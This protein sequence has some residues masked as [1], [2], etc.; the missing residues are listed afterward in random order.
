MVA[1]PTVEIPGY[2]DALRREHAVRTGAFL[3]GNEVLCGVEVRPLS[4]RT[5]VRLEVAQN[6]FVVP[7]RFD[8]NGEAIAHA[9]QV[10]WFCRPKFDSTFG[11]GSRWRMIR[12]GI[13]MTTFILRMVTTHWRDRLKIAHEVKAWIRDAFMDAPKGDG[14]QLANRP[15]F[16]AYPAHIIDTLHGYGIKASMDEIMD[17][18]LKQLWQHWRVAVKRENPKYPLV[19]PS[20]ELAVAAINKR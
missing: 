14:K 7:C 11:V 2:A 12:E 9:L 20:D 8:N 15:S 5:L 13:A 18:P 17:M 6:G 16:A 4:L 1:L 3:G 19:N 10:I